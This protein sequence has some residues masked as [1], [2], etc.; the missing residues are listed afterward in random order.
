MENRDIINKFVGHLQKTYNLLNL[1]IDCYPD[2]VNRESPEID[3]I[4]GPFAIEHTSIDTVPYQRRNS[5]WFMKVINDLEQEFANLPF[6]L[7]IAFEYE[8]ITTKQN[9]VAIREALK[10]WILEDAPCLSV[11]KPYTP[12]P[13]SGIPFNIYVTKD[14]NPSGC[15]R[16]SRFA[17]NDHT[18]SDRIKELIDKKAKKLA[19]YKCSGKTTIIL[20]ENNDIALMNAQ[21]MRQAIRDA[22]PAGCPAI[23]DKIWYA[24][25]SVPEH[26]EFIDVTPDM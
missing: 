14:T 7:R 3:A 5:D 2:D 11:P 15:V 21:K 9:W 10:K 6:Y 1:K 8:A 18:L 16:F 13:I 17:P 4:A 19:K 12:Y 26:I 22:Y 25:T 20:I 24:N 23:T